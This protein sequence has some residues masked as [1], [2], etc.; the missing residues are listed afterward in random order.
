MYESFYYVVYDLSPRLKYRLIWILSLPQVPPRRKRWNCRMGSL[1]LMAKSMLELRQ[2][3]SP[4][5]PNS[6]K[7]GSSTVHLSNQTCGSTASLKA[8]TAN[9]FQSNPHSAWLAPASSPEPEGVVLYPVLC[10]SAETV[11]S[12]DSPSHDGG[13]SAGYGSGRSS[14]E[15]ANEGPNAKN[16]TQA[17]FYVLF[18]LE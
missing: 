8:N 9:S 13:S 2:L 5:R 1:D 16:N 10:P 15:R 18:R 11:K 12:Q 4:S 6:P 14:P 7:R 17:F 3:D